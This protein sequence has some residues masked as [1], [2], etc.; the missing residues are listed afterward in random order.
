MSWSSNW[1][2]VTVNKPLPSPTEKEQDILTEAR[3][4]FKVCVNW[5]ATARINFEYDYKFA[6]GDTHNKYQWDADALNLRDGRPCLTI[7]KVNQHN[8]MVINDAKQ[9]KPGVRIRPVGDN[10]S[11]DAAQLFQE[12]V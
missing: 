2:D 9:N 11:Y 4:R 12:L 6:N 8:L 10:A 3:D 7:N 5:E 1:G